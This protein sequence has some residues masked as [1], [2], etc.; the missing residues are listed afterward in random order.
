M[1]LAAS[2]M[3]VGVAAGARTVVNDSTVTTTQNNDSVQADSTASK[4]TFVEVTLPE[5][6]D[7]VKNALLKAYQ[8]VSVS[9]AY[10]CTY[11]GKD[12][13]RIEISDGSEASD[14]PR[15]VIFREDG[16]EVK[17]K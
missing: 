1:I 8:G 11:N 5:V 14:K 16:I 2:L 9:K 7:T 3:F 17:D 10:K 4:P 13:Y 12:Y 6:P 15:A